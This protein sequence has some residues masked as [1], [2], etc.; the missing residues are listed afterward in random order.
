MI[1]D[2][3]LSMAGFS[4]PTP[5][6]FG[7]GSYS[8]WGAI[9]STYSFSQADLPM[10]ISLRCNSPD[11]IHMG[12]QSSASRTSS[13]SQ[14]WG[15]IECQG[16]NVDVDWHGNK[17]S[18]ATTTSTD[19]VTMIMADRSIKYYV[20]GTL[21]HTSSLTVPASSFPIEYRISPYS[22]ASGTVTH[23]QFVSSA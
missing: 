22:S 17:V 15:N 9:I 14:P 16:N 7:A 5:G 3:S 23:A 21:R 6:T 4:N 8:G 20:G 13:Y 12:F 11:N 1:A 19:I 2:T 18:V 10:G